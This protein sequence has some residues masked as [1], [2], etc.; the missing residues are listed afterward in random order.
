MKVIMNYSAGEQKKHLLWS[1]FDDDDAE[2][3]RY[4]IHEFRVCVIVL[5]VGQ[6]VFKMKIRTLCFLKNL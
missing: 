2:L 4:K 1:V 5:L 6:S 3:S